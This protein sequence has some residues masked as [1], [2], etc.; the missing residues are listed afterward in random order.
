MTIYCRYDV[1][2]GNIRC[3]VKQTVSKDHN[4]TDSKSESHVKPSEL[5][6]EVIETDAEAEM[7]VDCVV[8]MDTN[9]AYQ[10][11]V[12]IVTNPA[13]ECDVIMDTNPA[14]QVTS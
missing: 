10:C 6:Y 3:D 11:D 7:K 2:Q 8:N 14:Y 12:E 1:K 9:P 4:I 13:Y 5:E